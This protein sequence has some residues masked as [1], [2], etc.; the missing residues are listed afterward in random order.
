L[1]VSRRISKEQS[2]FEESKQAKCGG[3]TILRAFVRWSEEFMG[4]IANHHPPQEK[5][6]KQ[7]KWY[8]GIQHRMDHGRDGRWDG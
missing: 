3:K 6:P 1:H 8:S 2:E 5:H 7:A 4:N